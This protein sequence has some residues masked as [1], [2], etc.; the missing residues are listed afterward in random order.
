VHVFAVEVCL[1][2]NSNANPAEIKTRV[3]GCVTTHS[4]NCCLTPHHLDQLF[5][6]S[7]ARLT[8]RQLCRCMGPVSVKLTG[9]LYTSVCQDE[10]LLMAHVA[11]IRLA[12]VGK[13][14]GM[15]SLLDTFTF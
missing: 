3:E 2:A 4:D 1:K 10:P 11:T 15:V 6:T 7:A 9:D 8:A 13:T 14:L 12:D 5:Q